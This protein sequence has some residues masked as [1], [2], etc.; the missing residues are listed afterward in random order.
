[1]KPIRILL[2]DDHAIV[3]TGLAFLLGTKK[4]FEIVGEASDG[5]EAVAIAERLKPDVVLMDLMMPVLDGAEATEK[6]LKANPSAKVLILTSFGSES[7]VAMSLK[8]GAVGALLKS[9]ANTELVDAIRTVATGGKAISPDIELMMRERDSTPGLSMRQ[10]QML[11]SITRGL[12]NEEIALQYG[13]SV[14]SVKTHIVKLFAKI[15]AANRTEAA[16]IAFR[17]HLV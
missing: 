4:D 13:L 10:R 12:T 14:P 9:A 7:G 11:E 6:I 16:T 8:K 1:M 15:G 17:R 3:R 2:A 5:M